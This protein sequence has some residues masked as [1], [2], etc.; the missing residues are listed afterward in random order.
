MKEK[1]LA[2]VITDEIEYDFH[3]ASANFPKFNS[4]HEGFAVILEEMDELKA[5]VWKN[6]KVR[7]IAK[8]RKEAIKLGAMALRFVYD[9]CEIEKEDL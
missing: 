8:M 5:E 7:D 1:I 2:E 4:A 3:L 6:Q 9:I